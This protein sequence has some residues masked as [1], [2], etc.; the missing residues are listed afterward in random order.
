MNLRSFGML[1]NRRIDMF[2]F[3]IC[4]SQINDLIIDYLS[5]F[6]KY[7]FQGF[8]DITSVVRTLISWVLWAKFLYTKYKALP[9]IIGQVASIAEPSASFQVSM[10][11]DTYNIN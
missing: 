7:I 9:T 11:N 3:F 5:K 1:R 6:P 10:Y 8:D 2:D 4:A